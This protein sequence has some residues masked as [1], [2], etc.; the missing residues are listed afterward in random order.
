MVQNRPDRLDRRVPD[1]GG[2]LPLPPVRDGGK[3]AGGLGGSPR[4][5]SASEPSLT[6]R[7]PAR[8]EEGTAA[9][10]S[11]SARS[12]RLNGECDQVTQG[13]WRGVIRPR[14]ITP[15]PPSGGVAL[16]TGRVALP[17]GRAETRVEPGLPHRFG[18][19]DG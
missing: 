17:A 5:S 4:L 12:A 6:G 1:E 7:S 16:S 8:A 3:G 15:A 11:V 9:T 14:R 10:P 18:A 13:K 2:R 19:L